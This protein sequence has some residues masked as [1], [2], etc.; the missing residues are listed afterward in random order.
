MNSIKSTGGAIVLEPVRGIHRDVSVF[1][2]TSLYPTIIIEYNLSPET[3]NCSCCRGDSRAK[4]LVTSEILKGCQ[5]VAKDGSCWICQRKTGFFARILNA[6]TKER[7]KL[8]EKW[9]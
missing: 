8:Q 5:Y 2:A 9:P 3:V 4:R 7:I 1:D 6:L